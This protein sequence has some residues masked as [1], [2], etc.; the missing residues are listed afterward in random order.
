MQ[1]SLKGLIA[2]A[3]HE[4][5]ALTKYLDSVGVCTIGIGATRY[6]VPDLA[7]WPWDKAITVQEAF[8]LLKQS[9]VKYEIYI[10]NAL[11]VNLEQHEFDALVSICYNIGPRAATSTFMKRINS[12][13]S[14]DSIAK[15][16]LMWNKPPEIIGRRKKEVDLFVNG[17]YGDGKVNVFP[18]NPKSHKPMYSKGKLINAKEYLN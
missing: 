14:K 17:N 12:Y 18:I 3:S 6:E 16:I 15:A 5:V 4:G 8:D 9:I 11:E 7:K 2:L 13:Q 10:H 1:T